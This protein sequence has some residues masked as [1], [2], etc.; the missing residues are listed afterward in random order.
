MS[1]APH[2]GRPPLSHRAA[3]V[4]L[5][6]AAAWLAGESVVN[7][8]FGNL[9]TGASGLIAA[10]VALFA[11]FT[12]RLN[13][14]LVQLGSALAGENARLRVAARTEPGAVAGGQAS[15]GGLRGTG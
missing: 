5:L 6:A 14:R 2:Q 1:A 11:A 3:L 4:L 15:A 7:L 12:L 8:A 10:A 13:W 9:L